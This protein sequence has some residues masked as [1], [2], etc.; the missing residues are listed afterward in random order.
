MKKTKKWQIVLLCI[1]CVGIYLLPVLGVFV[2]S[3]FEEKAKTFEIKDDFI[4]ISEGNIVIEQEDSF[5]SEEEDI[6]Y[7]TGYLKNKTKNKYESIYLEYRLYDKEGNILGEAT[8]YLETLDSE[9]T[10]KFKATYDNLDAKDVSSFEFIEI[11][12]Y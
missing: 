6:Y 12:Y 7:V 11:D 2:I 1:L 3:Y 4:E 9:K 8:A 5:Y 10:W